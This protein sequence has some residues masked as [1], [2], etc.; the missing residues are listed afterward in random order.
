MK[1]KGFTLV[2]LLSVIVI[3]GVLLIIAIPGVNGISR[4]V[5]EQM[6]CNKTRVLEKAARLYGQDFYDDIIDNGLMVVSVKDLINNNLFEK[7]DKEC[8]TNG[9]PCVIDPRNNTSLDEATLTIT[10][11]EKSTRAYYDFK[12]SDDMELCEGKTEEQKAGEYLITF[13]NKKA[14]ES[15]TKTKKVLFG[16]DMDRIDIPKKIYSVRFRDSATNYD[17]QRTI[18]HKFLGYYKADNINS[19]KYF[20]ADGTAARSYNIPR[21]SIF[22]AQWEYTTTE[23]PTLK[24]TGYTF[25]GW[26][27][28]SGNKIGNAGQKYTVKENL[29][30]FAKWSANEYTVTLDNQGATVAGST[31]TKATY[32]SPMKGIALPVKTGYTFK[33]YYTGTNGSGDQYYTE[34]GKSARNWTIASNKTLYAY[35]IA[36]K[37]TVTLNSQSSNNPG[38]QSIVA[39]YD[40]ALP[41]ISIPSRFYT[42]TFD[43]NGSGQGANTHNVVYNFDGYYT[44]VNGTGTKYI[45]SKGTSAKNWNIANNTTLYA[46][47]IAGNITL[48]D[49]SRSGYTFLGWFTDPSGGTKIGNPGMSFSTNRNRVLYAQW[50]RNSYPAT[51]NP[52]K[53]QREYN[54]REEEYCTEH[55]ACDPWSC[56]CGSWPDGCCEQSFGYTCCDHYESHRV[57]DTENYDCSYYSCPNGGHLSG[58]TCYY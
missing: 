50:K 8:E 40:Q 56:Y 45:N 23:F 42:I 15:G 29:D 26:Y 47:W 27:N 43:Y 38:T 37:Y 6:F 1:N 44:S 22:Y 25:T 10:V 46:N 32:N 3:M 16:H 4:N 2:E 5:K 28:S 49:A 54:C 52:K 11:K 33:G 35:W 19:T 41:T 31:S 18:E 12:N 13:N 36:N 51:Y 7:E 17:I 55:Y 21:D 24:R 20:N 53:C 30:L 57:C 58:T 14:T 9:K 39:T 48:P 34:S